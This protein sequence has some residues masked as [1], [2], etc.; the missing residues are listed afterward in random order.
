LLNQQY[1]KQSLCLNYSKKDYFN[2]S[3][4]RIDNIKKK[5]FNHLTSNN[6]NNKLFIKNILKKNK[7]NNYIPKKLSEIQM[8]TTIE[9]NS[10]K[11]KKS[12]K[13]RNKLSTNLYGE[14]NYESFR[15]NDK[16]TSNKVPTLKNLSPMNNKMQGNNIKSLIKLNKKSKINTNIKEILSLKGNLLKN[17]E[18]KYKTN[19]CNILQKEKDSMLLE[20]TSRNNLTNSNY[21]YIPITARD[22][23][24]YVS[25]SRNNDSNT[26]LIKSNTV[27][28]EQNK[29]MSNQF[30]ST[31]RKNYKKGNECNSQSKEEGKYIN[32]NLN[33]INNNDKRQIII[34]KKQK[35]NEDK[36]LVANTEMTLY[37]IWD[38]LVKFCKENNLNCQKEG[39]YNFIIS[40]RNNQ[41]YFKVEIT[42][43]SPL[44][45]VKFFHGKNTES[46]MKEII[47]KLFIQ[48]V[49]F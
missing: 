29:N 31:D 4:S 32:F 33:K 36:F 2:P 48:I 5:L 8:H 28:L 11:I 44:N 39:L 1:K 16:K 12:A 9:N 26:N 40:T 14:I 18:K 30:I 3:T 27:L 23:N 35:K 6:V 17:K 24:V 45:I 13:R 46:K 49:N 20:S 43:L 41:N 21:N 22:N 38:K 7:N 42:H 34:A 19:I 15:E 10:N 47:T 37:Q 25:R